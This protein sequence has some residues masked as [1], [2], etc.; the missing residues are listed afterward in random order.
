ML[1]LIV[2]DTHFTGKN[3][4]ARLDDIVE[5]QF[6]KLEEIVMLSNKYDAP[7]IHTGDIFNVSIIANS[8]LTKIGSILEKLK[9]PLYFV[10]GN[11]DLMYH[12]LDLWDRTSLGVLWKNSNK[13][14][15]IS[16]FYTDYKIEFD[17]IDWGGTLGFT[18]ANE[19]LLTHKAV[20]SERKMGKGS[21]ILE[22][23][24]FCMN[25]DN[26]LHLR[27][28]KLIICGH[29][30]KPYIFKHKET[31]VI[32][33]GPMIR[34]T[35]DEWLKPSIVLINTNTLIHKRIYLNTP[36]PEKVLSRTHIEQN[37]ES[38]TDNVLK[39]IDSLKNKKFSHKKSLL[40]TIMHNLDVH[41]LPIK[42]ETLIR[43]TIANLIEK[44][45]IDES[46]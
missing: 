21:W 31:L 18:G 32:N 17:Y 8:I 3:P 38:V 10:W 27:G 14:K 35:I 5:I 15:H 33:P 12:S 6:N 26:N 36:D 19:I 37:F 30:H 28:Y 22:D 9:H 23:E 45:A 2:G 41:E 43:E 13:V 4:I 1:I 39:F 25:I 16:E 20:V 40:K 7:I 42:V 46:L 29:W 44:G 11:H 24:D 34:H